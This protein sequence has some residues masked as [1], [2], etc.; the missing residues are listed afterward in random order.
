MPHTSKNKMYQKPLLTPL[1]PI[2]LTLPEE[3]A[4]ESDKF[5]EH[6]INSPTVNNIYEGKPKSK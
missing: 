2:K 4:T 1:T 6:S 3:T 5:S